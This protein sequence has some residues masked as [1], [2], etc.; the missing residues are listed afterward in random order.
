M[1]F[2]T[3][4]GEIT[5]EFEVKRIFGTGTYCSVEVLPYSSFVD[6]LAHRM[7]DGNNDIAISLDGKDFQ[8]YIECIDQDGITFGIDIKNEK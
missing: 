5:Y 7:L 1:I 2:K 8:A 6:V 3:V 4:L